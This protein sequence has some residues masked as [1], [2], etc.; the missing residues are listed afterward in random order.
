MILRNPNESYDH[1]LK[2]KKSSD[3]YSQDGL[4]GGSLKLLQ[5]VGHSGEVF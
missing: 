4:G 3:S 5:I 1:F 2:V